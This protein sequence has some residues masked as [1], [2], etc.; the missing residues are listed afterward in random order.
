[1]LCHDAKPN[2]CTKI[3]L[4]PEY[5]AVEKC[6]ECGLFLCKIHMLFLHDIP[7]R[8]A[9]CARNVA[10]NIEQKGTHSQHYS[11]A[12]YHHSS[13]LLM[14]YVLFLY[15]FYSWYF[16]LKWWKA[17][18]WLCF[19]IHKNSFWFIFQVWSNLCCH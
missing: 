12:Y 6:L 8:S 15:V 7:I 3:D 4:I 10:S 9:L 11:T 17:E 16:G 1:M 5:S 19:T 14:S 2:V 13:S 18:T